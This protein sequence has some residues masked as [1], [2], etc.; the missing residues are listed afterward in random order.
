MSR[1][2]SGCARCALRARACCEAADRERRRV[3]RDLHDGAQ[4]RLVHTVITLK[5]ARQRLRADADATARELVD[6][7]L[8]QAQRATDELRELAHGILPAVL[9]RGGLRAA[10]DC[11]R[12]A[13]A[14]AGRAGGAGDA[15]PRPLPR[16]RPTS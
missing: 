14:A 4:Q 11:A 15:V 1:S 5:L 7:A 2:A 16:R 8:E 3:V 12:V 10:A 13:H 6:T 9:A